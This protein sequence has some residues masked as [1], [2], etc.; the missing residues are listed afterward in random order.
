MK[1]G[2]L[3]VIKHTSQTVG[4]LAAIGGI[5]AYNLWCKRV[6]LRRLLA[7][8]TV[9][10]L[11]VELAR[12]MLITGRRC[13]QRLHLCRRCFYRHCFPLPCTRLQATPPHYLI[14]RHH[15]HTMPMCY[16]PV[17]CQTV[18]CTS[19]TRLVTVF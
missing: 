8:I 7:G 16:L 19:C 13:C 4:Y 17:R 14:N 11:A 6:P 12:L 9:V 15:A 3:R 1:Y 2:A 10:S 5:T 18:R